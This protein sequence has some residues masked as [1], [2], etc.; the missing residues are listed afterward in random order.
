MTT[1]ATRSLTAG[2]KAL[3]VFAF[4]ILTGF[5]WRV[6]GDHGY[7]SMWGMFAVGAMMTL[8][9]FAFFG[10]KKKFTYEAIPAAIILLGITNGGWGTLNSQ[11]GGYLTSTVPFTGEAEASLA[12]INPLHG[13][14]IMLLLGFGWMPLFALFIASLFSEREYKIRHYV[15]LVAVF[16]AV[17]YAFKFSVSHFI[18]PVIHPEA[19]DNF[20]LGLADRDISLTPMQA[21]FHNLG[22]LSWAKKIPFGRN[23][24]T[25]IDVISAACG[26]LVSSFAA[27]VILRDKVT[28][29][30]SLGINAVCAVAITV[31]DVF[32]IADSDRGFLASVNPPAFITGCAWS[33]WEYFT[34]FLL[35]L[36]IMIILVSLPS[37]LTDGEGAFEYAPPFKR[38][39][40]HILYTSIFTFTETFGVTFA[41]P[42]GE[43]I[44][45]ILE[46]RGLISDEAIITV[47]MT[48]A[49]AVI[50]V[51]ISVP[52]AR[53]SLVSR[54]LDVPVAMRT[55]DFCL[56]AAPIYFGITCLIYFFT[57]DDHLIAN[58][59]SSSAIE[60]L[61]SGGLTIF[62]LMVVSMIIFYALYATIA[63]K[64]V[65]K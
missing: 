44:G 37:R 46:E 7:G 28:A 18:L 30:V 20:V 35:G 32:L 40:V 14:W 52:I 31:A 23:Y 60:V 15:V 17:T 64:S 57:D 21:Y 1:N 47:A 13:L 29:F 56:K 42:L 61:K 58:I 43:R 3:M 10:N 5:M 8:F 6:R 26:A 41:R 9:I 24:F 62:I 51:V 54:G 45:G 11:M 38:K 33:L 36:G 53:K 34:G 4:A 16:Y 19:V 39:T 49:V 65:K 25:S 48:A 2:T 22:D 63:K 12:L 55:E 27:L 50:G 59:K